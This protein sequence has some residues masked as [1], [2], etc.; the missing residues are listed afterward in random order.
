MVSIELVRSV[1]SGLSEAECKLDCE[2]SLDDDG[3]FGI[4]RGG[5]TGPVVVVREAVRFDKFEALRI[6][7]CRDSCSSSGNVGLSREE[8]SLPINEP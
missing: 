8:Y 4:R 2:L 5:R 3:D 7:G 1:E 6:V